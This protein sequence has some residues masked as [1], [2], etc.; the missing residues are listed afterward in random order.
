MLVYRITLEKYSHALL[1]SGVAAR[2]NSKEVR[3]IY[4]ASSRALACLENVVHRTAMGLQSAFRTMLIEVPDTLP[5]KSIHKEDLTKD[6]YQF[7]QFPHTQ[8]LGNAWADAMETAILRVP[9]A[10]I[11]EECN[12]LFNPLHPDFSNIKLLRTEP[13]GFDAR[14]KK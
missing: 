2:W 11:A 1:A 4:A 8:M 10:T 13:L 3:V 9:S 12:Y 14:I 5:V 6:W 7:E